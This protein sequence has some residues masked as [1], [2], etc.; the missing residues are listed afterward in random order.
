MQTWRGV[1]LEDLM[2]VGG[3]RVRHTACSKRRRTSGIRL[4]ACQVDDM[5]KIKKKLYHSLRLGSQARHGSALFSDDHY[6][7]SLQCP[8]SLQQGA[9][10]PSP[11]GQDALDSRLRSPPPIFPASMLMLLVNPAL[12]PLSLPTLPPR[13]PAIRVQNHLTPAPIQHLITH[14]AICTLSHLLTTQH[15]CHP[16]I[17]PTKPGDPSPPKKTT[18]SSSTLVSQPHLMLHPLL[19]TP[20]PVGGKTSLVLARPSTPT[21]S[22]SSAQTLS[23]AAMAQPVPLPSNKPL[24]SL[25]QLA[26]PSF[27][28]S[29]WSTPSSACSTISASTNST[30]ALVLLWV[31][32]RVSLLVISTHIASA[33]SSVLAVQPGVVPQPSQCVSPSEVVSLF[34]PSSTS[35]C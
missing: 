9:P 12:S 33:R 20:P 32:C 25:G 10:L 21:I 17:S 15:L 6:Q 27:P 1:A 13:K 30:Q 31:P 11:P 16:S 28:Y 7:R 29:T 34:P 23:V 14:T 18:S 26:S 35:L 24:A 3:T 2:R 5:S 8:Y 4:D 22:L 19:P